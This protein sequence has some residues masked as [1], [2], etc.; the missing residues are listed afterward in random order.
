MKK[1]LAFSL[2]DVAF[3][4]LMIVKM[5]TIVGVFK[6]C[7]QDKFRAELSMKPRGQVE[8]LIV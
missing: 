5:P 6:I 7:G 3:I 1:C 4:M 2:S 8:Y